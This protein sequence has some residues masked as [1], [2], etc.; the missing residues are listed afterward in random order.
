MKQFSDIRTK[1]IDQMWSE[2][3]FCLRRIFA[4]YY[5]FVGEKCRYVIYL[6]LILVEA[7]IKIQE[8][9]E[10][11]FLKF[12]LL[13]WSDFIKNKKKNYKQTLTNGIGLYWVKLEIGFPT[14]Q[15]SQTFLS[16]HFYSKERISL[17]WQRFIVIKDEW[18]CYEIS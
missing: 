1:R 13:G 6:Q 2:F 14:I 9:P 15:G 3:N 7:S 8:K 4:N 10:L 12:S 5:I 17:R 18:R 16:L 11:T